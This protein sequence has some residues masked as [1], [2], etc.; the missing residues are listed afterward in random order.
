MAGKNVKCPKCAGLMQVPA[1]LPEASSI[2]PEGPPPSPP[3]SAR[4]APARDQDRADARPLRRRR[5]RDEDYDDDTGPG[6]G[7]SDDLAEVASV[8][9]PYRNARALAAYYCGVFGLIPCVGSLLGPVAL[10]L[11]ILGLRYRNRNPAAH[12]AGHAITGIVLGSLEVI[13][14]VIFP[15]VLVAMGLISRGRW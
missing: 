11:G 14:Y 2:T 12:G 7:G 10:V 15:L 1:M 4:A 6:R 3:P 13:A 5:R 9:I 8:L